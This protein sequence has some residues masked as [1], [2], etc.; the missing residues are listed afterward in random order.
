MVAEYRKGNP[1]PVMFER[2]ELDAILGVY[3]RLVAQ[4]EFRDYAIDGL[5]DSCVF[6]IFRRASEAPLYTIH[7]TP[8]DARRQGAFKVVDASGLILKRGH[9]IKRVLDVFDRRRF[10]VVK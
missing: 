1:A 4:G 3:G 6:S 8:A 2:R 5:R 10:R 7:K 9:D